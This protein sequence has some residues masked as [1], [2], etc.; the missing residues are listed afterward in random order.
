MDKRRQVLNKQFNPKKRNQDQEAGEQHPDDDFVSK[1][2]HDKEA[3]KQL[4]GNEQTFNIEAS[5]QRQ[6]VRSIFPS[7]EHS[8]LSVR[9]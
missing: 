2:L 7:R 5:L 9:Q 4:A 1:I 8:C 6:Q 3:A